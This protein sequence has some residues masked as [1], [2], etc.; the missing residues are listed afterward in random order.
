MQIDY[1]VL[2]E[3]CLTA[4]KDVVPESAFK[5]WFLPII[6]IACEEKKVTIQVPTQ[7]FYEYL[8]EKYAGILQMTL[9][10][11][12]GKGM[13]LNYR[14]SGGQAI[15]EPKVLPP[16]DE[17][18]SP[19]SIPFPLHEPKTFDSHL[20]ARYVFGNFVEGVSNKLART[21]AEAIAK[22][23]GKTS[24]NP[25]FIYGSSGIGKTHLCHAI[26][27][28]TRDLHPEKRVLYISSHIFQVQFIDAVRKN[29]TNDFLN[30]Y[31]SLDVLILDDIQ[32]LIGKS[33]TQN[34][35]FHIFNHLHHL[36]KQL[37]L[38]SDKPP[39]DLNG[40]EERLITRLKWGLT[41]EIAKP[42]KEL[43][44]KI[45][46]NKIENEGIELRKEVFDYIIQRVTDNI[47]DLEGVLI[48]LLANS[49][50]NSKEIDLALARQV[51]SQVVRIEN[52]QLSVEIILDTVCK[53]FN[54]EK[55]L[56]HTKSRKQEIVQARQITMYLAKKLTDYSFAH[57]GK[58]V[59]GK[60]H[61]TVVHACKTVKDQI[62]I[63]KTFRATVDFIEN[64]IKP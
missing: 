28:Q 2:W 6:P 50:I 49:L 61:A 3:R 40:M 41:A 55:S 4:I 30:F 18:K 10:R 39:I 8:E 34:A 5:T 20:N 58:I 63:N 33:K 47:R 57:I 46:Q 21:A 29:T 17:T 51:V 13:V 9:H 64:A 22:D 45:L 27:L 26:G 36:G 52:R 60:D 12:F 62:E 54:L 38:T 37:I 25:L 42:D 59:G 48:S 43:R 11:V 32:E 14:I 44:I 35:F 15:T 53:N 23:P 16:A 56:I 31:Q 19:V 24:F 1:K 7:F